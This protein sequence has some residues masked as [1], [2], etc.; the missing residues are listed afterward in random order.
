MSFQ[1]QKKIEISRFKGLGEMHPKQLKETTMVKH[2][3]RLIKVEIT[4]LESTKNILYSCKIKFM[5]W[6]PCSIPHNG[7]K[8]KQYN[9]KICFYSLFKNFLEQ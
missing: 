2:T 6:Y 4:N 1:I 7:F 9:F 5:Y 8:N 3:R